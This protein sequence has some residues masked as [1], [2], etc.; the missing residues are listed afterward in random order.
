MLDI[1]ERE[2]EERYSEHELNVEQSDNIKRHNHR[3]HKKHGHKHRVNS[4][5][6]QFDQDISTNEIPDY[7]SDGSNQVPGSADSV[8]VNKMKNSYITYLSSLMLL[9]LYTNMLL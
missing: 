8:I 5:I 1:I 2:E 3:K 6:D 7:Y 9:V 4:G